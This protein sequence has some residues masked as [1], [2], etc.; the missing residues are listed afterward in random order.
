[1]QLS[2]DTLEIANSRCP[3]P[4]DD[5]LLRQYRAGSDD[6]GRCLVE[7]Y[8]HRVFAV[9]Y[10]YC[11]A[12]PDQQDRVQ[13]V[14]AR[15]LAQSWLSRSPAR[16]ALALFQAVRQELESRTSGK[17][18]RL[19]RWRARRSDIPLSADAAQLAAALQRMNAALRLALLLSQMAGLSYCDIAA[20]MGWPR[21]EVSERLN[22]ARRS[23]LRELPA[24]ETR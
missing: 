17:S 9:F 4:D 14:M 13:L 5:E 15:T 2:N 7:R 21:A 24:G 18:S 6:A 19:R 11:G 22:E 8:Q 1:M 10:W 20:V 3:V 23:L 12:R 16:V